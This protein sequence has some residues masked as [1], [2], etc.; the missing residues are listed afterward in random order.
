MWEVTAGT[1]IHIFDKV[2]GY[3][4]AKSKDCRTYHSFKK[5]LH[6]DAWTQTCVPIDLARITYEGIQ[7][8]FSFSA[9]NNGYMKFGFL[10][11]MSL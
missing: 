2:C 11:V 4:H 8:V 3:P 5:L 9:K 1:L 10:T 7:N 6:K